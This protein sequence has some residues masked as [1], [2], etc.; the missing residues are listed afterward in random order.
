MESLDF[1]SIFEITLPRNPKTKSKIPFSNRKS[2]FQIENPIFKSIF[3]IDQIGDPFF[4]SIF[5]VKKMKNQIDF[6]RKVDFANGP[7]ANLEN[8]VVNSGGSDP[9]PPENKISNSSGPDDRPWK[10][11]SRIPTGPTPALG[12]GWGRHGVYG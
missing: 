5:D 11:T 8:K 7:T 12:G 1:K 4:K 2:H 6:F 3:Y 10:T 9:R